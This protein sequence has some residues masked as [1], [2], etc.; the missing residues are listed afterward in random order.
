[1]PGHTKKI[2]NFEMVCF[3]TQIT[4]LNP[5]WWST[6]DEKKGSPPKMSWIASTMFE[7]YEKSPRYQDYASDGFLCSFCMLQL[8]CCNTIKKQHE[9]GN[10][11]WENCT[12]HYTASFVCRT[13]FGDHGAFG[14]NALPAVGKSIGIEP[15]TL[16][17]YL[18]WMQ[19][20][21]FVSR[22]V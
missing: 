8:G 6:G 21:G 5:Q 10:Q 19:G 9:T 2:W 4:H 13:A 1:M 3:P 20:N 15:L 18:V 16:C 7:D 11:V 12:I 14:V 22:N 17:R